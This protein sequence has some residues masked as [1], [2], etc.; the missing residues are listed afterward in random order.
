MEL[1]GQ[2]PTIRGWDHTVVATSMP[3]TTVLDGTCSA[4]K[5]AANLDLQFRDIRERINMR[6]SSPTRLDGVRGSHA[7]HSTIIV[8]DGA[9]V[10]APCG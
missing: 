6:G 8:A 1:L 10:H 4:E 5:V 7:G 3:Y 9:A 2:L